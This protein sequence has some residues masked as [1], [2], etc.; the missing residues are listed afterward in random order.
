ML[1]RVVKAAR[2]VVNRQ[3]ARRRSEKLLQLRRVEHLAVLAAER[4]REGLRVCAATREAA[5]QML[6]PD[7]DPSGLHTLTGEPERFPAVLWEIPPQPMIDREVERSAAP[8]AGFLARRHR[9]RAS[10][11]LVDGP[12]VFLVGQPRSVLA[13][14]RHAVSVPRRAARAL[15]LTA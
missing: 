15:A 11:Q 1:R 9:G 3:G 8:G 12:I 5:E 2:L 4:R 6:Q 7:P 13:R 14:L 10:M